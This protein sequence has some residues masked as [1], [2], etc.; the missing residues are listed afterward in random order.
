MEKWVWIYYLKY[1]LIKIY[2][3][4]SFFFRQRESFDRKEMLE[5]FSVKNETNIY[6]GETWLS[7]ATD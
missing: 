7:L 5:K 4:L 1:F 3:A 6:V 2:W